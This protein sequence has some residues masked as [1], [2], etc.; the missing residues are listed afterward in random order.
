MPLVWTKR[1]PEASVTSANGNRTVSAGALVPS[2]AGRGLHASRTAARTMTKSE[3]VKRICFGTG[4]LVARSLGDPDHGVDGGRRHLLD[5]SVRP[6]DHELV[7][8]GGLAETEGDG[9][10]H[11]GQIALRGHD[12]PALRDAARSEADF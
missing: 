2:L 10:L 5:R 6:A 12:Q 8:L 3:R 11:L 4:G 1:A 9:A 7:D